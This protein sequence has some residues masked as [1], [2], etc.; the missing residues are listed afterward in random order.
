[1]LNEEII[2]FYLEKVFQLPKNKFNFLKT[3]D[4]VQETS[5]KKKEGVV[6]T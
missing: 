5:C 2:G 1:M 4:F 6:M 3:F